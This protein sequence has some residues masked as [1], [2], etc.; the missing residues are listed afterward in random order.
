[1]YDVEHD[2]D[3]LKNLIDDAAHHQDLADLRQALEGWMV[4]THDPMLEVFRR[5]HD[6]AAREAYMIRVEQEAAERERG[7]RPKAKRKAAGQPK[8]KKQQP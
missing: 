1:L 2:P 4:K 5:R 3:C 6:P 7:E 8:R